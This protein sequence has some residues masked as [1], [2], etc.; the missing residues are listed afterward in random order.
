MFI[1]FIIIVHKVTLVK[2]GYRSD[3]REAVIKIAFS[4]IVCNDN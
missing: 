2:V 1:F 4:K 3:R